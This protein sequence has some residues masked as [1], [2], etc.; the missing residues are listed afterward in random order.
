MDTVSLVKMCEYDHLIRI[1]IIGNI[2]VGKTSLVERWVENDFNPYSYPTIG[3]D[4][5][6]TSRTIDGKQVRVQLYDT[7]GQERFYVVTR[8]YY[9]NADAVILVYDLN[10]PDSI[11]DLQRWYD[12]A[13]QFCNEKIPI[14]II[15][16]KSDKVTE[17]PV[18]PFN[19]PHFQVS[20]QS[21]DQ[22]EEVFLQFLNQ[23][24]PTL[25]PTPSDTVSLDSSWNF[26][27]SNCCS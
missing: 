22:M 26:Q 14:C 17:V 3:I 1:L 20:A 2:S 13:R 7:S 6:I 21:G 18:N 15:G 23:I 24:I 27:R 11:K 12:R 5:K 8:S 9:R 19:V 10:Q 16:N 4:F 25:D